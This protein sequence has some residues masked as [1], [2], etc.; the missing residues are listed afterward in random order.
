MGKA[1]RYNVPIPLFTLGML[2]SRPV[3]TY[4]TYVWYGVL[5]VIGHM[6][7]EYRTGRTGGEIQPVQP[8]MGVKLAYPDT[9]RAVDRYNGRSSVDWTG[10]IQTIGWH[11]LRGAYQLT[12]W[13]IPIGQSDADGNLA[14]QDTQGGYGYNGGLYL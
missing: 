6:G 1:L 14:Y 12:A 3:G 8:G 9:N 13:G 4:Q 7:M 5:V 10:K 11:T 2:A